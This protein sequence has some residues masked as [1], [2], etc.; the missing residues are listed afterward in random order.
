MPSDKMPLQEIINWIESLPESDEASQLYIIE[1][2][3]AVH[4]IISYG[5]TAVEPLIERLLHTHS[6]WW[7]RW[8]AIWAL[9]E[10]GDARAIEPL[11][12][13][14]KSEVSHLGILKVALV[15][16][17]TFKD[18][19]I[20]EIL[21][22][23]LNHENRNMRYAAVV[24]LGNIGDPRALEYLT[25]LLNASNAPELLDAQV[26]KVK[27][28]EVRPII[29]AIGKI[30]DLTAIQALEA[31]IYADEPLYGVATQH[32]RLRCDAINA[33]AQ[34]DNPSTLSALRAALKHSKRGVRRSAR[35]ALSKREP[36]SARKPPVR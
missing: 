8:A 5:A 14:C 2:N 4:T 31:I 22:P 17:S 24:A 34:I 10:I 28:H 19:R 36:P 33:I 18:K 23:L 20:V 21:I 16:L 7:M 13:I 6:R 12:N 26:S 1:F 27:Y 9:R 32:D 25:P 15:A 11:W 3:N 29:Q 30:D 35:K